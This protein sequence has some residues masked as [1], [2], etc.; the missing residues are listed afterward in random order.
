MSDGLSAITPV[1]S[2][3]TVAIGNGL[4]YAI[5]GI[6]N[7]ASMVFNAVKTAVE[8]NQPAIERL[9][10]AFDNVKNSIVNAFSGNGTALIQTLSNVIIPAL[11]N[12]LAGVMNI[13]SGVITVASALSPVIAGIAA[14]VT[15]YKI[16]VT[17]ANVVEGIRNG[18]IAFSAVMTGTQAAAF[19][20]LTT[21]TVAQIAAT[22]ALNVVTGAFGFCQ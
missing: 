14:A 4:F 1:V 19:A 16:A 13:A 21:A 9:S 7:I 15:A 12:A 5:Q 17:A 11:C 8:N 2:G 18:L 10:S 22:S 3:V 20:P 6:Y